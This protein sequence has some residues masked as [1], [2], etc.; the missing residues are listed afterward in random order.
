MEDLARYFEGRP[1]KRKNMTQ[2]SLHFGLIDPAKT[3]RVLS[4]L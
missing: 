3:W 4:Y 1:E 2:T